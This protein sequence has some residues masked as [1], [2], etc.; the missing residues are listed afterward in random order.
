MDIRADLSEVLEADGQ[1]RC[2]VV[3]TAS[4]GGFLL[5]D[6]P[7]RLWREIRD[8][9]DP[10]DTFWVTGDGPRPA[11]A[12]RAADVDAA[13]LAL[14][15]GPAGDPAPADPASADPA[16]AGR[17]AA[18]RAAAGDVVVL[19]DPWAVPC[20]RWRDRVVD[21][22]RRGPAVVGIRSRA[23]THPFAVADTTDTVEI[24]S[25]VGSCVAAVGP[26]TAAPPPDGGPARPSVTLPPTLAFRVG[27]A[28]VPRPGAVWPADRVGILDGVVALP[29]RSGQH[30]GHRLTP[31]TAAR[32]DAVV[33]GETAPAALVD[34]LACHGLR[35]H[36]LGGGADLTP[37][38]DDLDVAVV[39][40]L[41][42]ADAVGLAEAATRVVR[43]HSPAAPGAAG[44]AIAPERSSDHGSVDVTIAAD[45]DPARWVEAVLADRRSVG[46]RLLA[47]VRAL[48]S[49]DVA[50]AVEAAA[51]AADDGAPA[52]RVLN[53]L[54]VA[55]FAAGD[56]ATAA[57]W[58]ERAAELAPESVVVAA[59]RA[60]I[61]ATM[62]V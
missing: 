55:A 14:G 58:I 37:L 53:A 39:V 12:R 51:G 17:A 33:V 44:A 49:G 38:L 10:D 23:A 48:R 46:A 45:A 24:R 8:R 61:G 6:G 20:G 34:A 47:C 5:G 7:D 22:V 42:D 40:A 35:V 16:S 62:E 56:V 60:V 28:D 29:F 21:A 2:H 27:S 1:P 11:W 31:L 13:L 19:L 25:W 4:V 57:V 15:A 43:W 32:G 52:V 36:H 3:L 30:T 18:D 41:G 9:L 59:N 26:L 54:A 50:G